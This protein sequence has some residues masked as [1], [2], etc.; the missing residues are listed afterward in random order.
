[1][2]K[3]IRPRRYCPRLWRKI[4]PRVVT[5]LDDLWTMA[6]KKTP[7][8]YCSG[9]SWTIWTMFCSAVL[10]TAHFSVRTERTLPVESQGQ[11]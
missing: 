6:E 2:T 3:S 5:A 8:R 4:Q 1:M 9:R 10:K 7:R 11:A